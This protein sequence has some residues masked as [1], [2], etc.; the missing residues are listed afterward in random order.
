MDKMASSRKRAGD[1]K[2][3]RKPLTK[4]M[5]LPMNAALARD[6]SLSYHVALDGWRRGHGNRRIVN[7]LTRATYM[8]WFLQS[9]GYGDAPNELF[10]AAECVGELALMQAH[11]SGEEEGWSLDDESVSIFT[12]I[13]ALHDD[14]LRIAP[15]H[16]YENAERRLLAFLHGPERSPIPAPID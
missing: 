4:T 10:Q 11:E 15:L 7:E 1:K 5:L 12:G 13:L 14:Q 6:S 16:Q 2:M 9:A 3:A 8:A